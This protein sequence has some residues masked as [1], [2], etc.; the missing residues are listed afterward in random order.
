MRGAPFHC[1][2]LLASC[3]ASPRQELATIALQDGGEPAPAVV[4][5]SDGA[6]W[7]RLVSGEWIKGEIVVLDREKLE[8]DS[9]E[10]DS[11]AI[12][13]SDVVEV[14]T[15]RTFTVALES[16]FERVGVLRLE[17]ERV[18]VG[19]QELQRSEVFRIVPGVPNG[20]G[21]WSGRVALGGTARRG[22]TDQV[23]VTA[24]LSFLR[25][26][27]LSRLPIDYVGAYGELEGEK[28]ADNHRFTAQ[29]DRFVGPRLFVTPLGIELFH[30]SFQNV[31]LRVA[32]FTALGYTVADTNR[33]QVDLIGGLGY[34]Y[35]RYDSG[36]E[37]SDDTSFALAGTTISWDPTPTVD[38]D[39]EYSAQIG[40]EDASDTNQHAEL[41]LALD[42]WWDFDLDVR[43]RWTRVGDPQADGDGDVPDEDD[44]RLTVGLAWE[45]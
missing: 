21:R 37:S 38:V 32:P 34:R 6:D 8:F 12:D 9:A 11:L 41:V 1:V 43:L 19:G 40:L 20:L 30:D 31:D 10:L 5:T 17:G 13:W 44:F 25:R 16:G 14:R 29:Y 7:V 42:L 36:L 3:A 4:D 33:V 39:F 45:L 2:L 18:L 24:A 28:S 27:A 22:N 35:T 15:A 26:T 23:D